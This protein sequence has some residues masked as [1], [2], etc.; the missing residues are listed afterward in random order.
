[1]KY[2]AAKIDLHAAIGMR[3]LALEQRVEQD[4]RRLELEK[5]LR[6]LGH[7]LKMIEMVLLAWGCP[8]HTI[9]GSKRWTCKMCEL[10]HK[11]RELRIVED[12][13][14]TRRE[15]TRIVVNEWDSHIVPLFNEMPEGADRWA[16]IKAAQRDLSRM[17]DPSM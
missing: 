16:F 13:A 1:M 10:Q 12:G 4:S 15:F 11:Q 2:R 9:R 5:E 14:Y 3:L 8:I 6:L 7:E 17:V